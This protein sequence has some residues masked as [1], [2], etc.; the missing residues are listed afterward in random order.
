MTWWQLRLSSKEDICVSLCHLLVKAGTA[1]L[2][3]TPST[4]TRVMLS[5]CGTSVL[6]V[7][8]RPPDQKSTAV[9]GGN[10]DTRSIQAVSFHSRVLFAICQWLLKPM[11]LAHS[12]G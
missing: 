10:S 4:T 3:Q 8:R 1:G 12:V 6:T 11:T 7:M 5:T 2:S 9:D